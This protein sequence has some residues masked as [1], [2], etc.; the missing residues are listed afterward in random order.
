MLEQKVLDLKRI[1]LKNY[2]KFSNLNEAIRNEEFL[3][4]YYIGEYT[5]VAPAYTIYSTNEYVYDRLNGIKYSKRFENR[6]PTKMN[7]SEFGLCWMI[8]DMQIKLKDKI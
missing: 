7:S 2:P 8:M 4:R 6:P 3:N 1:K 5:T